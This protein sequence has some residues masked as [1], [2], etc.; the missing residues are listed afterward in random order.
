MKNKI[1]VQKMLGYCDSIREYTADFNYNQ[2]ENNKM[3]VEACV[4]NLLQMGELI[5][6]F[7]GEF[8]ESNQ[9]I[10][11]KLIRGLRHRLVHDYE[12]VDLTL[13]WEIITNDLPELQISLKNL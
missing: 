13:V 9:Q 8:T 5:S 2:F 10:P 11:W 12:G 4:F 3:I 7:D 6:K 1:I